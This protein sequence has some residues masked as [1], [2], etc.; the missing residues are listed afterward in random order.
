[1][2][3]NM[4]YT[5][6]GSFSSS[7]LG[8]GCWQLGGEYWGDVDIAACMKAIGLAIELG[9]NLFDTAP[10]YG[11]GLADQR[12]V[13]ALGPKRHDVIIATKVGVDTR[14]QH[15]RSLLTRQFLE[16]DIAH[17]LKRLKLES[18]PLLQVH[19]P[20]DSNTPI[21]ETFSTLAQYQEKGDIQ[22]IGVCNYPAKS[23]SEI[24]KYVSLVSTQNAYSM[25]RR[26]IEA[27]L[28]PISKKNTISS[29]GY[30]VL[31]RGL[32]T[33][34]YQVQT[35]FPASDLRSH[36]P[37]FQGNWLQ[38]N[39]VLVDNLQQAAKKLRIPT[40]AIPIAWSLQRVDIALMGIKTGKQLLQNHKALALLNKPKILSV[41]E[42][43]LDASSPQ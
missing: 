13:E 34:K 14:G 2:S 42:S 18:I 29:I 1:M 6:L 38:K 11:N 22:A 31:C 19:W 32:L 12:L 33:G 40:S 9:I 26:E 8:F 30:E 21:E 20:C 27:K 35:T 24:Q 36:D 23:L 17:S 37:R 28:L 41:I 16:Q 25:L 10:L 3:V 43:I 4:K 5:K 39:R 15:A 7:I